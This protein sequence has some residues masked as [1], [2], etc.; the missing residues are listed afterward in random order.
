MEWDVIHTYTAKDA[1][2]DGMLVEVPEK[3]AKEA[4]FN[5]PVRITCGV[6][7]LCTPPK[8]NTTQT[9]EGRLWDVL[10][11][12]YLAIKRT[13]AGEGLA[14]YKVKIGR[15]VETLWA[16]VDGTCGPAI[17]ILTPAEY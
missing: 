11:L 9:Y 1:V 5:W 8:S 16:A 15:K 2:A 13:P 6:H 12:A 10:F 7:E 14:T 17:H 3:T 4:G